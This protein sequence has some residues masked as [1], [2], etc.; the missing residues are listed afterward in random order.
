MRLLTAIQERLSS[1][2]A[3]EPRLELSDFVARR[4]EVPGAPLDRPEQLLVRESDGEL[5]LLLVLEDQLVDGTSA[6][7]AN[8]DTFCVCAE[9]VSHLLYVARAAREDASVSQLELEVQAEV[10]KFALLLLHARGGLTTSPRGV[11]GL[12]GR[13]FGAFELRRSVVDPEE[14]TRYAEANRLASA[15]CRWLAAQFVV[16]ARLEAM[17]GELR[18]LYRLRGAGKLAYLSGYRREAGR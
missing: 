13:L 1:I 12:I 9:G 2:Y 11:A 6:K 16:T 8:L 17:I 18:R 3:L 7:A 4:S 10:D 15:Y 5:E 14:Q